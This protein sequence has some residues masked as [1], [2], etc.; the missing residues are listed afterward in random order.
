MRRQSS[1][2]GVGSEKNIH[3]AA[4]PSN[5]LGINV[6]R[7]EDDYEYVIPYGEDNFPMN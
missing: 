6:A 2:N 3:I 5:V 4:S 7:A 1:I